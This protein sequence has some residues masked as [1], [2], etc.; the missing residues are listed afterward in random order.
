MQMSAI[1]AC[2]KVL[3]DFHFKIREDRSAMRMGEEP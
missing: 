3:F 2:L 1:L